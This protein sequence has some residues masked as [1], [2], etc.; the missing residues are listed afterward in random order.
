MAKGSEGV[1]SA[2]S[3]SLSSSAS[4]MGLGVFLA[5]LDSVNLTGAKASG[6]L[7]G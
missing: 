2:S 3:L 7:G 5:S 6:I 1:A 4:T